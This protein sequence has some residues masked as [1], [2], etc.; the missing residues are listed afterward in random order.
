MRDIDTIDA[1][2]RLSAAVRATI[3]EHGSQQG[4]WQADELLDER[5]GRTDAD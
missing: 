4:S 3:R 1:E 2:L 5:A